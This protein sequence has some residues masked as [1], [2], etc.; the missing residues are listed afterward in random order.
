[1]AQELGET[2]LMFLVHPTL[3][4]ADMDRTCQVIG[5]VLS[6]AAGKN[7]LEVRN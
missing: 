2:S 1:V 6:I 3:T 5:E 7:S 4:D